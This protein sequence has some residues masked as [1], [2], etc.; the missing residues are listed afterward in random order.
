MYNELA[1]IERNLSEDHVRESVFAGVKLGLDG[2]VVPFYFLHQVREC[3]P[4]T[5]LLSCPIDYPYGLSD[6]KSRQVATIE[7]IKRGANCIDLMSQFHY[8]NHQFSNKFVEDLRTIQN[9]CDERKV[10]LRLM[11]E[12]RMYENKDLESII[13][14]LLDRG[15]AFLIP[16]SGSQVD[17]FEDNLLACRQA[18]ETGIHAICNGGIYL[19][20]QYESAIDAAV[21]G[22]RFS[23]VEAA[24]RCMIPIRSRNYY[25][26]R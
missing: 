7:A 17:D 1:I 5:A 23:S 6:M 10:V 14:T 3:L 26:G 8:L 20:K 18:G 4:P 22:C 2:F 15:I 25:E 12:Y 21:Y 11:F 19:Q 16:A 9:I 13:Y 24:R